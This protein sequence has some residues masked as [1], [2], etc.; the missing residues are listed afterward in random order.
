MAGSRRHA[1]ADTKQREAFVPAPVLHVARRCAKMLQ[2]SLPSNSASF[3]RRL[4]SQDSQ[5]SLKRQPSGVLD[6]PEN[7]RLSRRASSTSLI[8]L[9]DRRRSTDTSFRRRSLAKRHE[10]S[11]RERLVVWLQQMIEWSKPSRRRFGRGLLQWFNDT[12][13]MA[14]QSPVYVR[15]DQTRDHTS[16]VTLHHRRPDDV[17]PPI[18][19]SMCE[20]QDLRHPPRHV[21]SRRHSAL[22]LRSP[23]GHLLRGH[24]RE[25]RCEHCTAF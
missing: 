22:C 12:G 19:M 4:S 7:R 1:R 18:S 23:A 6:P 2:Q 8:A 24:P 10:P 3:K 16:L 25:R 21:W 15:R 5:R 13:Y 9:G 14:R 20:Q 11:W 17:V